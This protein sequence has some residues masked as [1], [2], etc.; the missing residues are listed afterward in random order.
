VALNA[1][2]PDQHAL[3]SLQNIRKCHAVFWSGT[4]TVSRFCKSASGEFKYARL[5][6]CY[7]R[8]SP[9]PNTTARTINFPSIVGISHFSFSGGPF[10]KYVA[11]PI[12]VE[13]FEFIKSKEKLYGVESVPASL[14][15]SCE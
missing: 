10:L 7:K 2:F 12:E 5:F 13:N 8:T 6:A 1:V 4:S 9:K 11:D 3:Y 14:Y 15:G